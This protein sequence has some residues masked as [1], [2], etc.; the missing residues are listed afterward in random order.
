LQCVELK[1]GSTPNIKVELKNQKQK[2]RHGGKL[3]E[4]PEGRDR[5][6]ASSRST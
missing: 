6:I 1:E 4:I 3:P 2:V 5:K